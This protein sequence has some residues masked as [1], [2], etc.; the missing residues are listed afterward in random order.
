MGALVIAAVGVAVGTAVVWVPLTLLV[1]PGWAATGPVV[2]ALFLAAVSR[3]PVPV[4][5]FRREELVDTDVRPEVALDHAH[6]A[7]DDLGVA[8][9]QVV[10]T[11]ARVTDGTVRHE[12]RI[13]IGF[14]VTTIAAMRWGDRLWIGAATFAPTTLWATTT[15]VMRDLL[16]VRTAHGDDL[17]R[18]DNDVARAA[19][20]AA[21]LIL[22]RVLH[23][24]TNGS[25]PPASPAPTAD[26]TRAAPSWDPHTHS[27]VARPQPPAG[28]QPVGVAPDGFDPFPGVDDSDDA[29][30]S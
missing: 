26:V 8:I 7:L 25:P 27:P 20:S 15:A 30:F 3:A 16:A 11:R 21:D 24:T 17:G 22:D 18:A 1:S 2:A 10:P 14:S 13:D 23:A 6:A 5:V 28:P 4:T 9:K 29:L 19:G 12:L